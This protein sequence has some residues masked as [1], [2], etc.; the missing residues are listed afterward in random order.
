MGTSTSADAC[1]RSDR[2][3]PMTQATNVQYRRGLSHDTGLPDRCADVITCSQSLHWMEPAGT[4]AEAARVLRP[5]GV[6]AAYDCSWPPL[7]PA[8]QIDSEYRELMD[9]AAKLSV[10]HGLTRGLKQ[11]RKEEHLARMRESGRFRYVQEIFL[12]SIEM[13]N[14]ERLVGLALSQ[15]VVAGLLKIGL[16]ESEIGIDAFRQSAA[17]LL[18]DEPRTWFFSYRVRVGVV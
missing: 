6:F 8:W 14:A 18:G 5:G 16:A 15:G 17:N 3:P 7:T 12:H 11:W 9:R 13:G 4:F 10:R 1:G 2:R